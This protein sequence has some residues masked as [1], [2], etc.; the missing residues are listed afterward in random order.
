MI[1][2]RKYS[3]CSSIF[4]PLFH[5]KFINFSEK[6]I[7]STIDKK[8]SDNSVNW[9]VGILSLVIGITTGIWTGI[10]AAIGSILGPQPSLAIGAWIGLL[11]G[12][13]LVSYEYCCIG[14][15]NEEIIKVNN[16]SEKI[17]VWRKGLLI[18]VHGG[19]ETYTVANAPLSI[20]YLM[21]VTYRLTGKIP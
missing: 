11:F 18:N 17:L 10:G 2:L 20:L 9:N 1:K 14:A 19:G 5:K 13:L 15:I 21:F 7:I 16:E 6:G 4:D 8:K 3:L 12:L